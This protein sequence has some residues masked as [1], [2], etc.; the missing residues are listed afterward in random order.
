MAVRFPGGAGEG[1]G[2]GGGGGG[3]GGRG[4]SNRG[5]RLGGG[6]RG[7]A[8]R[9]AA[10]PGVRLQQRRDEDRQPPQDDPLLAQPAALVGVELAELLQRCQHAAQALLELVEESAPARAEGA[11]G[12]ER[13]RR[14]QL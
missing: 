5:T 2:E 3:G 11:A 10:P 12:G 8:A 14:Q 4:A 6:R 9:L 13:Q 1:G 7:R